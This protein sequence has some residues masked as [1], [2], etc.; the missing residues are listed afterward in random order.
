[1]Q[2]QQR[3]HVAKGDGAVRFCSMFV[4]A[5]RSEHV[6]VTFNP[7]SAQAP[8]GL[9]PQTVRREQW[10]L[11]T[12]VGPFIVETLARKFCVE[13]ARIPC[14]DVTQRRIYGVK[15]ARQVGLEAWQIPQAKEAPA[16]APPPPPPAVQQPLPNN[17]LRRHVLVSSARAARARQMFAAMQAMGKA[18]GALP[19]ASVRSTAPVIH[20]SR[21]Q[22][23]A[24][25]RRRLHQHQRMR[26][27][28]S[29][30]LMSSWSARVHQQQQQR[31]MTPFQKE[32]GMREGTDAMILG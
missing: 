5:G 8:P 23:S 12:V 29:G 10:K 14:T 26:A 11:D 3:V 18:D 22:R 9:S 24:P 4:S 27:R 13:W 1:M 30:A 32:E 21:P 17:N 15:L 28:G 31:P 2:Q 25:P 7:F 16:A 6:C 19:A 20:T